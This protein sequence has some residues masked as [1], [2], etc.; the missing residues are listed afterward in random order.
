[1]CVCVRERASVCVYCG[2]VCVRV[3][4]F[5][6]WPDSTQNFLGISQL[7]MANSFVLNLSRQ[8]RFHH[9]QPSSNPT[10]TLTHTL[11]YTHGSGW[12][13]FFLRLS[14]HVFLDI[15]SQHRI[16]LP[17]FIMLLCEC[18]DRFSSTAILYYVAAAPVSTLILFVC[19]YL[20]FLT[21]SMCPDI[22]ETTVCH[23]VQ[24]S[25]HGE[26]WCIFGCVSLFQAQQ[27]V[28]PMNKRK[29]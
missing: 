1:M 28:L 27:P 10:Y 16:N 26:D 15:I 4:F 12:Q 2:Y 7:D 11:T 6:S 9:P 18:L 17:V 21:F 5:R 8:Q 19:S 29:R 22:P 25:P 20:D 23:G 14:V 13:Q 24:S 3:A